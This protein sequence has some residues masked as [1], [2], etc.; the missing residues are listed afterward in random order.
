MLA[1]Y[2]LVLRSKLSTCPI[3]A[4]IHKTLF[5]L[6]YIKTTE[7]FVWKLPAR[8]TQRLFF[9]RAVTGQGIEFIKILYNPTPLTVFKYAFWKACW[10]RKKRESRTWSSTAVLNLT[11]ATN[12]RSLTSSV[13]SACTTNDT[14]LEK[15]VGVG[16]QGWKW[17][18]S[19]GNLVQCRFT[20]CIVA[21]VCQFLLLESALDIETK[22]LKCSFELRVSHLPMAAPFFQ[23]C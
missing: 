13:D 22:F 16:L 4:K 23:P 1:F 3:A 12:I 18:S 2:V 14:R 19:S 10:G 17:L 7:F 20:K 8:S 21:Q 9:C 6:H 11:T 5:A 15:W